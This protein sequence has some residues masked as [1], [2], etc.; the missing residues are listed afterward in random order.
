MIGISKKDSLELAAELV[1]LFSLEPEFESP[2]TSESKLELSLG[3]SSGG[4]SN[5][6]QK[7]KRKKK[8]Q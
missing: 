2:L 4:S 1:I 3:K 5:G 8:L 6:Q 7:K